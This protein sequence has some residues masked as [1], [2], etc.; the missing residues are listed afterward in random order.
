MREAPG[1]EP[2]RQARFRRGPGAPACKAGVRDAAR[3]RVR[4]ESSP[5]DGSDR[6]RHDRLPSG[7]ARLPHRI[8]D[9]RTGRSHRRRR[10]QCRGLQVGGCSGQG[11]KRPYDPIAL[12]AMLTISASRA[13]LKM[14]EMMPWTVAVRRMVLSVMP[15]SET[16]AVMPMTKEK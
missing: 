12:A 1:Q 13:V 11:G 16:C 14:K 2:A 6:V 7:L 10:W 3:D 9:H 8:Q 15:T 4:I 5:R